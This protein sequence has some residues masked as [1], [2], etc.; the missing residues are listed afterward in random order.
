MYPRSLTIVNHVLGQAMLRVMGNKDVVLL[1]GHGNVV[2]GR[3]VEEATVRAISIEN[4]ARLCWQ[5]AVQQRSNKPVWEIPWEDW[6]DMTSG[7]GAR[8]AREAQGGT[9]TARGTTGGWDYYVQMLQDG[10]EIPEESSPL[11]LTQF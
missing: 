4:L 10:A 9:T 5:L 7:A 3:T 1:H 2:G 6:D 11:G 8:E